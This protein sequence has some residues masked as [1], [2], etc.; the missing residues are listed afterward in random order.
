[1]SGWVRVRAIGWAAGGR[2]FRRWRVLLW[3][4]LLALLGTV[5]WVTWDRAREA[6]LVALIMTQPEDLVLENYH[7]VLVLAPHCDDEILGAGGLIMAA[8]RLEIDVRV[9]IATNG[10]G[11]RFATM[12]DLR[13]LSPRN[14]DFIHMGMLRQ[15]ES[16]SALRSLGVP[17]DQVSFLG[18]PDRGLSALWNG[19]WS[20]QNPYRSPYSGT[21]Q[22]PYPITYDPDAVYAG[23]HLLANLLEILS[24]YHPDLIVYPHP[25]DVHPDHWSLSAFTRL[26]LALIQRQEPSYQPDAYVYLVHRSDFPIPSGF[27]PDASL[28]PPPALF[29]LPPQWFHLEMSESD[30]ASKWQALQQYTSQLGLLRGLFKQ[31]VRADEL[32]GRWEPVEM[33]FLASGEWSVP[34]N[35]QDENGQT[36][37]PVQLDPSRDVMV[38]DA[39]SAAD[40]TA[41]YTAMGT[42]RSLLACV[43]VRGRPSSALTYV[44]RAKLAGS[45]GMVDYVARWGHVLRNEINAG[46]A[47]DHHVCARFSLPE[48]SQ[49]W[50]VLVNAEVRQNGV[51]TLDQT[52][53][54]LLAYPVSSGE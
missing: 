13:R 11:F 1:M 47:Q 46:A 6:G 48:S 52:A 33:P 40:L 4:P 21:S 3:L 15:Q 31:F 34:E 50:L 12:E 16:L 44:L 36:I 23:E 39:V 28:L 41:V 54:Q 37:L 29:D 8:R 51:G 14:Q 53:W 22:S 30:V 5:G 20:A 26:A 24:S 2:R 49:P 38:H 42:D 27:H 32:F 7:R 19:H 35:W 43:R 17:F 18:Y 45:T 10:D 9:V 25:N